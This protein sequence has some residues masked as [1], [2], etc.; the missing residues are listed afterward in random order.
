MRRALFLDRDGTLNYDEGYTN[1]F[2]TTQIIEGSVDLIR[3]ANQRNFHVI[4][5]TNQ[6]GIGR[7]F[8]NEEK[9]HEYMGKM[10]NYYRYYGAVIDDYFFAPYYKYSKN[11]IYKMGE[12]LRKPNTGMIELAVKK[13]SLDL[14]NSILVGDK[15]TDI[16]T[17]KKIGIKNLILFNQK[18]NNFVF[19]K[20]YIESPN[21]K[22]VMELPIW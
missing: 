18:G 5:A 14:A 3:F 12:M 16:Q 22:F 20:N 9:F 6:S 17:G 8:Y 19:K 7:G 13:Y 11:E 4:I 10:I 15:K 1:S 2:D 21:L